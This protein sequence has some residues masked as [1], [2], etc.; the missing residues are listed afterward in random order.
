VAGKEIQYPSS[1]V[2]KY[3]NLAAASVTVVS[4]ILD[5]AVPVAQQLGKNKQAKAGLEG[6]IN[7]TILLTLVR[8]VPR[9]VGA[10]RIFRAQLATPVPK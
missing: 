10:V 8:T 9:L 4:V 5:A 7:M 2:V 6:A 3:L 1:Q